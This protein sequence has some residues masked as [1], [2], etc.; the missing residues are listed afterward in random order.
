[1]SVNEFVGKFNVQLPVVSVDHKVQCSIL[2][3][4]HKI[5]IH[6]E[7][8]L[9]LEKVKISKNLVDKGKALRAELSSE[10]SL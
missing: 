8:K 3:L 6:H 5:L 9:K 1:M 4:F 7:C 2:Q 10:N